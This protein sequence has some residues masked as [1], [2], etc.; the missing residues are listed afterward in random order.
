M[1][2]EKERMPMSTAGLTRYFEDSP[3][4]IRLKPEHIVAIGIS[5]VILEI[6]LYL[7]L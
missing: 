3:E 6:F 5:L 2:K 4:K 1:A 7:F